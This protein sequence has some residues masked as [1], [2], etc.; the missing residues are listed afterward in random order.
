MS[1]RD[2]LVTVEQDRRFDM[3][4]EAGLEEPLEVDVAEWVVTGG[5]WPKAV[6]RAM[7]AKGGKAAAEA[8]EARAAL[9]SNEKVMNVLTN[10]S[11]AAARVLVEA[12]D[13]EDIS[14]KD[15]A[16][17]AKRILEYV[18]GKPRTMQ[19][20]KPDEDPEEVPASPLSI[21]KRTA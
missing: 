9:T 15:K 14:K 18:V 17:I 8:R 2:E 12:L 21:T 6:A 19:A 1:L 10:G 20:D 16:E 4:I 3:M 13:D 5:P 7:G 11:E